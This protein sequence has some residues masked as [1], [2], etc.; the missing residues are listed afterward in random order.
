MA[1]N[2]SVANE[3]FTIVS[4]QLFNSTDSYDEVCQWSMRSQGEVKLFDSLVNNSTLQS[5]LESLTTP[6]NIDNEFT[7]AAIYSRYESYQEFQSC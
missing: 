4:N 1:A 3:F 7:S 2:K 5:V 6:T